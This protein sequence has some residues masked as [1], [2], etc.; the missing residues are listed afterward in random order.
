MRVHDLVSAAQ[1]S[2]DATVSHRLRA[3]RSVDRR[4]F[5]KHAAGAATATALVG[6][7]VF[8]RWTARPAGATH[9]PYSLGSTCYKPANANGTKC[10]TCGSNV[11]TSVCAGTGSSRWHRHDTSGSYEYQ[12]R[13]SSCDGGNAWIWYYSTWGGSYNWRCSDGR[14]RVCSDGCSSWTNS[15]CPT[16]I[17]C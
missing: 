15:V 5:V 4:T 17:C 9:S 16:T 11:T 3:R 13:T 14:Y 6:L 2:E 1:P 10:C 12:L 7:A 8:G